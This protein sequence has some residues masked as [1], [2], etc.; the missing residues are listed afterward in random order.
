MP[1]QDVL[2]P[3]FSNQDVYEK[4]INEETR[5]ENEEVYRMV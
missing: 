4:D 1:T 3:E 5:E 2:D